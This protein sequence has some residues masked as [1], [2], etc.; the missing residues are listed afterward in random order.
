LNH[1]KYF[2][3]NNLFWKN[4]GHFGK[5]WGRFGEKWGH[6]DLLPLI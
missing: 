2:F 5:K 3:Y 4:V 6:F 1:I